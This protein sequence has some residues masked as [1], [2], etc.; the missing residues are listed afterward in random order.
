MVDFVR[1]HTHVRG[2]TYALGPSAYGPFWDDVE[3]GSW[4][5]ET[6]AVLER[7]VTATV[8]YLDVGAFIGPT[9]LFAAQ[10]AGAAHGFEPDPVAF[11]ELER[12]LAHNLALDT[13]EL[14]AVAIAPQ[15]GRVRLGN[16]NMK[17]NSTSSMLLGNMVDPWEV[18]ACRL[19]TFLREAQVTGPVFIKMDIEGGEY[20]VIPAHADFLA[21]PQVR[22]ILLAL[23]PWGYLDA[24]VGPQGGVGRRVHRRIQHF[25]AHLRLLRVLD[26]FPHWRHPSGKRISWAGA[27]GNLLLGRAML[28]GNMILCVREV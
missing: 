10:C 1:S 17:G 12:H 15:D 16:R 13:V 7:H 22:G 27:I 3:G 23:H 11:S 5:P 28:T 19:D 24:A 21:S 20:A 6:F 9:L 25:L 26:S 18:P 8:T 4:E 14:H 2:R